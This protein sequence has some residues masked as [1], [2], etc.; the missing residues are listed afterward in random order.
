[1]AKHSSQPGAFVYV[2]DSSFVTKDNLAMAESNSTKFLSRLPATYNQCAQATQK[3]VEADAWVELGSL[4]GT[5]P[6]K[7]HP[8]AVY[9]AYKTKMNLY[10]QQ[11]RAIG[12]HSS[13]HDKRRPKR[14]ERLLA[15]KRKALDALCKTIL[16][17]TYYCR[18]DAETA[19]DKP[20][21]AALGGY[22]IDGHASFAHPTIDRR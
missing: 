5:V 3:A 4:A 1:M 21:T 18:A 11:N 7:R 17:D 16:S 8:V 20:H 22:Q 12:V 6:P 13:S 9:R 15:K 14:I 2:A 19:A 10:D